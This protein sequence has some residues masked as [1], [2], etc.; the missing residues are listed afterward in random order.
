MSATEGRFEGKVVAITGG[1][2]GIGR[3]YARR[4]AAEG[5]AIV[6]A[7]LDAEV[8]ERAAKELEAAGGRA[9]AV[10]MDVAEEAGATAMVEAATR[11]FGGVDILVNNAGVHLEHAQIPYTQEALPRWRRVLDVNVLGALNCTAACRETMRARGGGAV[12]NQSS[13]AAYLGGGAYGVSKLALNTLTVGLAAELAPD[14]IRVN[15]IAP[16][17]VDSEA[18]LASM[19]PAAQQGVIAGQAIKRLGRMEDLAN[20]A[21]FLCSEEASFVTGQTVLVDGGFVK[22]AW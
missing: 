6:V 3:T 7:D 5:A 16:S 11:A 22:K 8:G 17:L 1:G 20:M 18:A 9:V 21:L 4:F 2:M 19:A 12:L 15:G 13:M 10:A 14:G